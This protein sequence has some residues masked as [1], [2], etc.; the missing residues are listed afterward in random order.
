MSAITFRDGD[1]EYTL[2]YSVKS[3]SSIE[4]SGF[5]YSKIE[6][7]PGTMYP[8]F[9]YG[10]FLKHHSGITVEK[11]MEVFN[12]LRPHSK[13]KEALMKMYSDTLA[14]MA[15]VDDGEDEKE[16]PNWVQA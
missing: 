16:N 9:V 4:K 14:E 10:A 15:G 5:D 7:F 13:A 1:K 12:K 8:L 3:I 6:I 11:A 2:E